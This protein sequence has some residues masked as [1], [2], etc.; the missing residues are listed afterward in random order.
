MVHGHTMHA[1]MPPAMA[2]G[3]VTASFAIVTDFCATV[4]RH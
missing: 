1:V 4:L 3:M 2:A